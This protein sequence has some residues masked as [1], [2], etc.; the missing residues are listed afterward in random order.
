MEHIKALQETS[1]M[2]DRAAVLSTI[3]LPA[4]LLCNRH[5]PALSSL[6]GADVQD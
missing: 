4:G 5:Q 2:I 6:P 1:G 3:M